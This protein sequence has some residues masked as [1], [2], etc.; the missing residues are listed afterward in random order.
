VPGEGRHFPGMRAGK[1]NWRD[2]VNGGTDYV[3]FRKD[4]EGP[5]RILEKG[6]AANRRD[7][8]EGSNMEKLNPMKTLKGTRRL[9]RVTGT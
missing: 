3:Y 5:T 2:R 4:E 6:N 7:L 9:D 1:H 8:P